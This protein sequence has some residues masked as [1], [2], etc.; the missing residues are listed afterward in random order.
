MLE[1]EK[2]RKRIEIQLPQVETK[3]EMSEVY[4]KIFKRPFTVFGEPIAEL[5]E[6]VN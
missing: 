2:Q 3:F 4:Q 6:Q 5:N 1:E